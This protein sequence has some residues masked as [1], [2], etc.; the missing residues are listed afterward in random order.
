MVTSTMIFSS[1]LFS[2]LFFSFLSF[3]FI[4]FF[5]SSLLAALSLPSSLSLCSWSPLSASLLSVLPLLSFF[6]RTFRFRST[7]FSCTPSPP[8]RWWI[9]RDTRDVG[10]DSVNLISASSTVVVVA[11][12]AS[13]LSILHTRRPPSF[14]CSSSSLLLIF[15]VFAPLAIN[16]TA[17]VV[18][19]VC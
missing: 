11:S 8:L 5:V 6:Y 19:S 7:S 15:H 9:L 4:F 14:C 12:S 13:L 3:S 1:S 17:V 10:I 16:S 18:S 2:F